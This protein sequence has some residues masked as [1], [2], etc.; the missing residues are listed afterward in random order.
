M[1]TSDAVGWHAGGPWSRGRPHG[2][3]NVLVTINVPVVY[4]A[5]DVMILMRATSITRA[6][7]SGGPGKS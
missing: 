7:G 6:I 5:R 4:I 2:L 1:F 3:Y